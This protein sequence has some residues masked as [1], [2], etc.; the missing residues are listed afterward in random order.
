M[1]G[2]LERRANDLL[3]IPPPLLFVV[4]FVEALRVS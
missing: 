4:I 3:I 1:G 2:K